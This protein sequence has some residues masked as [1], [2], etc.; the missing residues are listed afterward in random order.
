M[1]T[2]KAVKK[3]TKIEALMVDLI[4]RYKENANNLPEM[5]QDA[6]AAVAR[7]KEA[8]TAQASTEAASKNAAK[9]SPKKKSANGTVP[10]SVVVAGQAAVSRPPDARS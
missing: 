2:N 4:A 5:L 8:V 9:T 1:K 7:A 10:S 3:L 6:K